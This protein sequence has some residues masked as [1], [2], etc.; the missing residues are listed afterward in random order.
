MR[1]LFWWKDSQPVATLHV[2][3]AEGGLHPMGGPAVR[4]VH[5]VQATSKGRLS[6][7]GRA[8]GVEA[9]GDLRDEWHRTCSTGQGA[10]FEL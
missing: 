2:H 4:T 1:E 8:D 9:R 7:G 5:V 3:V 10:L 6:G